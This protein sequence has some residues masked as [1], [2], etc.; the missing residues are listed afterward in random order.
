MSQSL[1]SVSIYDTL[2]PDTAVYIIN[3]AEL[4]CVVASLNVSA[5]L[6]NIRL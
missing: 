3:H 5:T 2:G 6:P 4:G 1:F